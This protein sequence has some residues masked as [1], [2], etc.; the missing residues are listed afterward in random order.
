MKFHCTLT[1]KIVTVIWKKKN[2]SNKKWMVSR[3]LQSD[4]ISYNI[5]PI[6]NVWNK[7]FVITL[8]KIFSIYCIYIYPRDV[9]NLHLFFLWKVLKLDLH[10]Y[11]SY[12]FVF[13]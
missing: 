12:I 9:W 4:G 13:N 11:L 3:G 5:L 2:D 8:I 10:C 7:F 6:I 1:D